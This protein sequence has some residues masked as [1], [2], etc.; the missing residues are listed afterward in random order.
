MEIRN[1]QST[2]VDM[3]VSLDWPWV[4]VGMDDGILERLRSGSPA[5]R[6]TVLARLRA[7]AA[8]GDP[9]LVNKLA[10]GLS[11]ADRPEEAVET[12]EK[13][14]QYHPSD[15]TG[16]LNLAAAELSSGRLTRITAALE[17][18]VA[19]STDPELRRV[20]QRRLAEFARA[21]ES[22]ALDTEL[23]ELQAAALQERV[24]LG[25]AQ[26]GDRIRLA[27]ILL[28]LFLTEN[29]STTPH[30]VLAAA[31]DAHAES[32]DDPTTLELLVPALLH[33]GDDAELAQVLLD[34][35]RKAPHSVV[36]ELIRNRRT[37]PSYQAGVRSRMRKIRDLVDRTYQGDAA[38]EAELRKLAR[39]Y[40][41][42]QEYRA[43][44]MIAALQREEWEEGTR[45]ADGLAAENHVEH[46]THFHVAQ[47]Y[48]NAGNE[49][50]ARHH[51]AMAWETARNDRDRA[52]VAHAMEVTGIRP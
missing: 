12:L 24:T 25:A 37:D 13:L 52:D 1:H 34:L 7:E 33:T 9:V 28:G 14:V 47:F 46:E 22:M 49:R 45:I 4:L 8:A 40:P 48:A 30:Q 16:W 26:P 38:A 39:R 20:A 11:Y 51:F 36:L 43:A 18:A 10:I 41:R 32:P 44:L 31:R 19:L 17:S 29:T 5:D 6:E 50:K 3:A 27:R 35:E 15:T 23:L 2:G 42:N 21:Q